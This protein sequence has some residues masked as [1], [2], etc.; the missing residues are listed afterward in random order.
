M[1]ASE[2]EELTLT[3]ESG[4]KLS[5]NY[6]RGYAVGRGE[7]VNDFMVRAIEETI[8]RDESGYVPPPPRNS[9]YIA[10][11]KWRKKAYDR[12]V[13]ILRKDDEFNGDC[14]K[15]YAVGRGESING[16]LVRAITETIERDE[17]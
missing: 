15:D 1:S 11:A 7:S 10:S 8:E 3:L 16:F 6:I 4:D 12:L 9:K 2:F 14:V 17:R 5:R 13:L